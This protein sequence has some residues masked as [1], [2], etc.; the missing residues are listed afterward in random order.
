MIFFVVLGG[1]CGRVKMEP[2]VFLDCFSCLWQFSAQFEPN[3][4]DEASCGRVAFSLVLKAFQLVLGF[5][6]R[7]LTICPFQARKWAFQTPK[8]LHCK[9]KIA[10]IEAKNA[11]NI[12]K[13]RQNDQWFHFPA[14]N[15]R[16]ANDE[17]HLAPEVPKS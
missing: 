2:F 17:R 8:T 5:Q 12:G 6:N 7:I 14:C 13:K 10:N 1:G 4:C 11:I 9:G 15:I 16:K 3:P